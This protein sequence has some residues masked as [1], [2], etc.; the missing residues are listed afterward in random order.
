MKRKIHLTFFIAICASITMLSMV[1]YNT[2]SD[3][4]QQGTVVAEYEWGGKHYITIEE[5]DQEISEMPVYRRDRYS[6]KENKEGYLK[7]KVEEKLQ[8]HA[9]EDAGL[10]KVPE[11]TEKVEEYLH[12]LMI[13]KLAGQEID[14]QVQVLE[15]EMKQY[16]EEHK[17]EYVEPEKVRLICITVTDEQR[18]KEVIERIQAGEDIG[19]VATELSEMQ[20]NVGPGGS[21]NGDTDFFDP[22]SY[23]WAEAFFKAMSELDIGQVTP[24]AVVQEVREEVNYMIFRK[25]EIQPERQKEFDEVKDDIEYEVRK[26]NRKN[27]LNNWVDGLRAKANFKFYPEKIPVPPKAEEE[28]ATETEGTEETSESESTEETQTEQPEQS[29]ESTE[30]EESK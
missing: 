6:K 16:Y 23:S 18:A 11:I 29:E 20:E 4:T 9:A 17:S 5:I 27:R 25:E 22:N 8:I 24:E 10:D 12:Q 3:S 13:E 7:D 14:E 30:S 15:D 2:R 26:I 1:S 28:E 19:E 21:S